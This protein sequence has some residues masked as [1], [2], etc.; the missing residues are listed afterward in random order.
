[1]PAPLLPS[2]ARALREAALWRRALRIGA[3][4]GFVQVALNQGN[5]WWRGEVTR[6]LILKSITSV[7]FAIL[8][9]LLASAA[10]R[11]EAIRSSAN[12]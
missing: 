8:V 2:Y 12:P 6:L 10:T 4:V 3:A 9:V 1:M 5:H 7:L 11:V